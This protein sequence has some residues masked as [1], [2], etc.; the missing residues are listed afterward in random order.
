[1]DLQLGAVSHGM[2]GLVVLLV[3]HRPS[4]SGCRSEQHRVDGAESSGRGQQAAGGR[5]PGDGGA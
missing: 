1:M 4:F 2:A 3:G 5:W